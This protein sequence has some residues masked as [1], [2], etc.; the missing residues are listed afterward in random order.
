MKINVFGNDKNGTSFD[1]LLNEGKA[2]YEKGLYEEAIK[3]YRTA[4]LMYKELNKYQAGSLY[5]LLGNAYYNLKDNDKYRYYYEEY[6]KYYPEGQQSIFSRLSHAYYYIDSD[7]SIDYHNKAL[8]LNVNEYDASCKLFAM[9]KSCYYDQQDIK[10][11]SEFEVN[12]I[13]NNLYKNVKPYNHDEKKKDKNKK[14]NIGYL[15]SDC[16]AHTMMN[17]I[18]PIWKN[19]NQEEFN[20]FIFNGSAKNDATTEEI[21]NIGFTM[22]PCSDLKNGEIAKLIYEKNIDILVDLGG[23]TH[24]KSF[25]A[26]YKP[27]PII[28]SYLGYLNTLG[29]KEFDYILADRF[30]IP[31]D[32]AYLY[33][34]KPLYLDE[35][36][37]IFRNKTLPDI[38][39]NPFKKNNY[40]TFGSFNCTSKMNDTIIYLWSE[41]LKRVPDSKLFI[42][43]TQ[44]TQ[45][46][47][48][49]LSEKFEKL[50]ISPDRIIFG[51]RPYK[52]HYLAYL[53]S[54][55]SLDTYP[56]GGMS[57]A[58]ENAMMGV[59]TVA[60]MGEGLQSRGAARI[61]N[62]LGLN[63]LNAECGEDYIKAA[64]NLANDK[65]KISK[66]RSELRDRIL[67]SKILTGHAEFTKNLEEKYKQAWNDF[68]NSP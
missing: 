25:V 63:E 48:K 28:I 11:N 12:Q 67:N 19:H 58:I 24:L 61:N 43:R 34:E 66:L 62:V 40:I 68:I 5:V 26:F 42:Y 20:F 59:P 56:F 41:I 39:A 64:V 38:T 15:S 44:M 4:L 29:I 45:S 6:L 7:K 32:K 31:E 37:Q 18:I 52:V 2:L 50:G 16:S 9:I 33:T 57:I 65:D 54:D 21:K 8:N 10:D 22:I 49:Y 27:A 30:S 3:V 13:R 23:Y 53:E 46:I 36:Y 14:L 17:Y 1:N 60:L 55:I 51:I 35:G 47:I